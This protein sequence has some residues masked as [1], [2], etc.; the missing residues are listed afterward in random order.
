MLARHIRSSHLRVISPQTTAQR[1]ESILARLSEALGI[2]EGAH[3]GDLAQRLPFVNNDATAGSETELQAAVGG[4]RGSVDLALSIDQSSFY[5]NLRKR[6]ATGDMPMQAIAAIEAF[7]DQEEAIWENSWIR[8]PRRHLGDYGEQVLQKDLLA[9]KRDSSGPRRCD[10]DRFV[11]RQQ[12]ETLLRVPISYLLKLSLARAIGDH[13][14]HPW[15]RS[16]GDALMEHFLNDNT[17]PETHSFYVVRADGQTSIGSGLAEETAL[18][19]LM[20]QLLITYANGRFDLPGNGQ[21]AQVYYAPHPPVRQKQL[22]GLIPDDFYRELFM[23][24]CL[25]GWDKGESKHRYMELCHQVLSRSQINAVAKLKSAGIIISNLVVLPNTSN[26]SLANNGTHVSLGSRRLSALRQSSSDGWTAADEKHCGDLA[27]KICEHFLPLFVGTYSAA[28]YRL[29]FP[30][31]HPERVLGFLPHELHATHLRMLW[32]RWKNKARLQFCGRA[33]TPFGP[34]W[35]DRFLA[36]TLNLKG[37]WVADFRLI[38]YMVALPGTDESPCL[39]GCLDND[40]RLK[41]DLATLGV[42][43]QQMPLYLLYRLRQQHVIGFSGFE[44]RYYS[45]F[46]GFGKDLAP[47]VD[48]QMLISAMAFHYIVQRRCTHADIPDT[49]FVESERRQIFFGA[50]IGIP[51]FYVRKDTSNRFL[52]RI[53]KRTRNIRAS[54]RYA[55]YIR[56]PLAAYRQALVALLRED[57]CDLIDMMGLQGVMDDLAARTAPE[58]GDTCVQRVTRSILGKRGHSDPMRL[59]GREFN[60]A[61]EAYYRGPLKQQH[62]NEAMARFTEAAGRLDDWPTWREGHYNQALM[63]IL[64]GRSA[65]ELVTGA[66]PTLLRGELDIETCEKLIHLLLLV[67]HQRRHAFQEQTDVR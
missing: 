45:L 32:R 31:F 55:G 64:N 38:D 53:L 26:I 23:S 59:S 25:S 1:H 35:L 57:G 13:G 67:I 43:H 66:T 49:P 34:E 41:A 33:L 40:L 5:R 42:F 37:D 24:P 8:F 50:A 65:A 10:C 39:D 19:Y 3:T 14:T 36:G 15:V 12:S 60:Q 7:L 27:I 6:A 21:Q 51:T 20:T 61:A 52:G 2:N 16:T 46:E 48:L 11:C 63:A 4:R 29:E 17:S 30:D 54:R 56:V 9:D 44:G 22:N 28:P 18:R 58:A 47:A 62:L